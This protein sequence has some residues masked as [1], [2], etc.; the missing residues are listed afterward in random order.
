MGHGG[1]TGHPFRATAATSAPLSTGG[2]CL[3]RFPTTPFPHPT[4]VTIAAPSAS[5]ARLPPPRAAL[6][7]R[8]CAARLPSGAPLSWTSGAGLRLRGDVFRTNS[9]PPYHHTGFLRVSAPPSSERPSILPT[10]T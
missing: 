3:S 10:A 4:T 8:A 7:H 2:A 5:I 6:P 1:W 9:P